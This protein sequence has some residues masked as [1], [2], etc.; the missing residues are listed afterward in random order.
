M[1]FQN[2]EKLISLHIHF[3]RYDKHPTPFILGGG[4]AGFFSQSPKKKRAGLWEKKGLEQDACATST[5]SNLFSFILPFYIVFAEIADSL[6]L[7]ENA[8]CK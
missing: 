5:R 7:R 3:K 2:I 4:G 1:N 6:T 8:H